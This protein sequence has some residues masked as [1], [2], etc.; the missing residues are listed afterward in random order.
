MTSGIRGG[1]PASVWHVVWHVVGPRPIGYT[2]P[3]TRRPDF[4]SLAEERSWALHVEVARRLP[5]RP[6][7]LEAARRRVSAWLAEPGRHPYADD[8]RALLDAGTRE[9]VEALRDVSPRMCTLRQASPF[10]GAL[11]ARTRWEI[12]KRPELR[13]REAS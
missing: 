5:S 1:P 9:L 6:D 3:M 4:H 2:T 13:R 12:L 10:A 7:L 8:W 11:D